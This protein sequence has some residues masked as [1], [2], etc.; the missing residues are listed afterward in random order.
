MISIQS[1]NE[2]DVL[3]WK[4]Y[5][6]VSQQIQSKHY[7]QAFNSDL[8][9]EEF[10]EQM[11]AGSDSSLFSKRFLV[12]VNNINT[13]WFECSE[14]EKTLYCMYDFIHE[15]LD[16]Q[17]L[18][19]ILGKVLELTAEA[20]CTHAELLIYRKLVMDH[21]CSIKAPVA[22][23]IL[24]SRLNR[25][26]MDLSY[27]AQAAENKPVDLDLRC[28]DNIPA[29]FINDFLN[30]MNEC[31]DDRDTLN[32]VHNNYPPLTPEQWYEDKQRL[33]EAGSKLE[34]LVLFDKNKIAGF[35]WVCVDSY[36]KEVI[37]HNG[38][39]TA[40][41]RAYRGRGLARYLKAKMYIKLLE[42]N[43]DFKYIT[44]DTMPWNT[45]M[46]NINREFGFK[47]YKKGCAFRLTSEFLKSYIDK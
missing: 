35:C 22:E 29:E 24:I 15:D 30:T 12:A 36:R 39:L 4:E 17:E 2:D 26:D 21:F 7:P 3:L 34:Y 33:S 1:I 23:E 25:E 37:R 16:E 46:Y 41:K 31:F 14:F 5:F 11:L 27:Y 9:F 45:Y 47:P 44:T 20:K 28:F 40:V 38:G 18:K 19:F 13:G 43:K 32:D 42:E 6:T 8:S 10:K